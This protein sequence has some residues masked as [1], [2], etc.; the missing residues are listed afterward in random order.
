LHF[1]TQLSNSNE[2]AVFTHIPWPHERKTH[3]L[4]LQTTSHNKQIGA[5]KNIP[6]LYPNPQNGLEAVG[7]AIF[8]FFFDIF[9][10]VIPILND[11]LQLRESGHEYAN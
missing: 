7:G 4:A 9:A 11:L 1:N 6:K 10:Y 8:K 5:T 3:Y 2:L